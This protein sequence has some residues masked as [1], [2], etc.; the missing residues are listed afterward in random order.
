MNADLTKDCAALMACILSKSNLL[1]NLSILNLKKKEKMNFIK[2]RPVPAPKCKDC[3]Y[4]YTG[5]DGTRFC[6]LSKV[7]KKEIT[8][9]YVDPFLTRVPTDFARS[10][11][12][13]CGKKARYFTPL[14]SI[15]YP[16]HLSLDEWF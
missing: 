11:E 16:D 12:R 1:K 7:I 4:S 13:L 6:K 2:I 10:N 9:D 14:Y 3:K 5:S 15:I 8:W